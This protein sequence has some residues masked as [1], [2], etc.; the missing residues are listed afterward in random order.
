M[1]T[2]WAI[3]FLTK[4]TAK[5]IRR[6]TISP[7]LGAGTLLGGR[8]LP[9]DLTSMTVAGGR[10]VSRP[11][12]GAIEGMLAVLED[13]RAEQADAAVAGL[14]ERL[15][16]GARRPA[17]VQGAVPQDAVRSRSGGAPGCRL[18]AGPDRR[19]R[20]G[21]DL[22][23]AM[24]APDQDE[25]VITAI[26]LGL[27]DSEPQDQGDGAADPVV[28]RGAAGGR[29]GDGATGTR[30]SGR[31]TWRARTTISARAPAGRP[32]LLRRRVRGAHQNDDDHGTAENRHRRSFGSRSSSPWCAVSRSTTR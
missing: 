26:R 21:A 32:R 29:A 6:I 1:N 5:T 18:G 22:I 10:V 3:L 23:D 16:A 15:R 2:V 7:K 19:S 17:A 27:A 14:V 8:E 30:R 28:S 24:V 11:M 13:P 31:S 25:E 20:R 9:K 12:N 4:S